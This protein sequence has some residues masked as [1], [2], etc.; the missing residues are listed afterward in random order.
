MVALVL[1]CAFTLVLT[2]FQLLKFDKLKEPAI[3][4]RIGSAY[5]TLSP[6][7]MPKLGR[8]VISVFFVSYAR[9]IGLCAVA[10]YCQ[11]NPLI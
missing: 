11:A 9:R 6:K 1:V 7:K 3:E 8:L 2:V 10:V 5:E 4:D